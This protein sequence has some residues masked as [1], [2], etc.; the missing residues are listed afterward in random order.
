MTMDSAVQLDPTD[1]RCIAL[2]AAKFSN[3]NPNHDSHDE[4]ETSF[5]PATFGDGSTRKCFFK[6]DYY[7]PTLSFASGNPEYTSCTM[8]ILTFGYASDR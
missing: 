7:D 3:F 8:R 4:H 6:F 5:F 1:I 2:A